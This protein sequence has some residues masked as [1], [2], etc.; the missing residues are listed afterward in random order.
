MQ[1]RKS[2]TKPTVSE[3]GSVSSLTLTGLTNPGNDAKGGSAASQG[4]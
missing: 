1:S 2:Y 3:L 4:T